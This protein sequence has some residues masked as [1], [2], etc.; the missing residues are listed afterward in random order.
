VRDILLKM[1]E[2]IFGENSE[3]MYLGNWEIS[4]N[5]DKFGKSGNLEKSVKIMV[6]LGKL[7]KVGNFRKFG[8]FS[9]IRGNLEI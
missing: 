7:G 9:E 5:L 8:K 6:T 4:G 2:N 1:W 3:N